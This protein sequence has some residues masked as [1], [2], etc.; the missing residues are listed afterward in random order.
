MLQVEPPREEPKLPGNYVGFTE[1][2]EVWNSRAGMI[3]IFGIILV[4]LVRGNCL[5]TEL[6]QPFEVSLLLLGADTK[7]FCVAVTAYLLC[8][9][10][11]LEELLV[12]CWSLCV[13]INLF[14]LFLS[15]GAGVCW[16]CLILL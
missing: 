7:V 9:V 15:S 2:A 10:H 3:G 13:Y 14:I 12:L 16:S 6:W 8:V 4:E 11:K 5:Q 1:N